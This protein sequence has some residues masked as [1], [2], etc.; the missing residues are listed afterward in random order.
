LESSVQVSASPEPWPSFAPSPVPEK[1][2]AKG[3]RAF[4]RNFRK[5]LEEERSVLKR[6]QS[7]Q[8]KEGDAQRSARRKE[9]DRVQ[10]DARRKFFSENLH[11]PERRRY[12]QE[13]LEQRRNFYDQLKSEEK[14]EKAEREARWKALEEQQ[15]F[16]WR[17]VEESL[18]RGEQPD[19]K[20][21][22]GGV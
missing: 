14:R 7:R 18:G 3:V 20:W 10:K 15:K 21:M 19:P 9:W 5:R 4:R 17:S 6:E 16:R 8:K 11:G 13:F 2:D 12:V 22:P 1:L